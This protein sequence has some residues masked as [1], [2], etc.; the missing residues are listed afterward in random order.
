MFALGSSHHFYLYDGFCD[1]RKSFDGLCGLIGSGM[2]RQATSGEVFVFLNRSR[3]HMKLLHWEK[4]SF[5]LYYKRLESGTFM[6]PNAKNGELSWSNLV[7]M[8]EGIQVVKSI[9]KRRFSLP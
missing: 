7:L 4:G 8:V 9:Q 5:V 1:M 6:P 3:T 2:Q